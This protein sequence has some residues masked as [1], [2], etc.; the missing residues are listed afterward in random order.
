MR[1]YKF[2]QDE[3][4][5]E[6]AV[7]VARYSVTKQME[8]G[9]WFYGESSTQRWIDNF[10]TGYNLSALKNIDRHLGTSEF[11]SSCK[12]GLDFYLSRF[13]RPDGAPRYYHDHTYP[14][15][16]HCVAQTIL[17]LLEAGST[18]PNTLAMVDKV[19]NWAMHHMWCGAGYFYYRKLRV[20]KVRTSYMRWSQAWMLKAL[21]NLWS[22]KRNLGS[23]GP[24]AEAL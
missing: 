22:A 18:Y 12:R 10:H 20:C 5:K 6:V 24:T 23:N 1:V 2:T 11:H 13:V 19:Y 16:I 3:R 14:I 9:S 17:T 8:D 21:A 4:F 7:A 15:D